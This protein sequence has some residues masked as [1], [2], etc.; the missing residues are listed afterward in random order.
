[1]IHGWVNLWIWRASY[2]TW[3]PM[4]FRTYGGSWHRRPV[5]TQ[6]Q[7]QCTVNGAQ[8]WWDTDTSHSRPL[9]NKGIVHLSWYTLQIFSMLPMMGRRL[10]KQCSG[11]PESHNFRLLETEPVVSEKE[12]WEPRKCRSVWGAQLRKSKSIAEL[13]ERRG[14]G[15]S[16][17]RALGMLAGGLSRGGWGL[18]ANE[19][20]QPDQDRMAAVLAESHVDPGDSSNR[21]LSHGTVKSLGKQE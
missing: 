13:S 7:L 20:G 5:D 4:D 16:M 3:A 15:L 2:R 9:G 6:G 14:G 17:S 21:G 12:W 11:C 8:V 18:E 19:P 1:M 10:G